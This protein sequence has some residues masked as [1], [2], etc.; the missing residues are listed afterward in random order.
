MS[1]LRAVFSLWP[2]EADVSVPAIHRRSCVLVRAEQRYVDAGVSDTDEKSN[3]W[4]GVP[5][6]PL[7][8]RAFDNLYVGGDADYDKVKG[9]K[10]WSVLRC[11]KEGA[12]GHRETVVYG[13]QGAPKGPILRPARANGG[14]ILAMGAGAI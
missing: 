4:V 5:G 11:C 10:G 1:V 2:A 12:G 9:V 7:M 3:R 13:T 6:H 14:P 8:E